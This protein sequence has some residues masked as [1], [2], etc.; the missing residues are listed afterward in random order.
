[1]LRLTFLAIVCS[2]ACAVATADEILFEDPFRGKLGAGWTWIRENPTGWRVGA[3]AL[4]VLVEPG[5]M[6]G[7]SNNA[8]NVL[9]RPL[10][11]PLPPSIEISVTLSNRPT[12]QY[13][14][15]DLAW[16]YDDSHM[17]KI[18]QE[19]VDGRLSIVM[20]REEKDRTRTLAII[21]LNSLTVSVR[22][23][24]TGTNLVGQFLLPGE[25]KWRDAGR[26]SLPAPE[27]GKPKI[28]LQFY[29]GPKEQEHWA[30]VTSF[31]IRALTSVR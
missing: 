24:V 4:E 27:S 17:V 2:L 7:P 28:S 8:S 3:E 20:G 12:E 18:G 23:V 14:Q 25:E 15:V 30:R 31:R 22:H 10:P 11:Y 19:M 1:M 16:Y 5:N 9:V 29:Q 21:P 13:E 26:C 6:W